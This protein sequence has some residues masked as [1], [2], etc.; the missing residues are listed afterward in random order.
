FDFKYAGWPTTRRECEA[1]RSRCQ[2]VLCAERFTS[3]G[4]ID[5]TMNVGHRKVLICT[6]IYYTWQRWQQQKCEFVR[7]KRSNSFAPSQ[8]R[9]TRKGSRFPEGCKAPKKSRIAARHNTL[10]RLRP[11]LRRYCLWLLATTLQV[12]ILGASGASYL[13]SFGVSSTMQPCLC[14]METLR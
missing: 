7:Q 13:F 11:L 3:G 8:A 12:R 5:S 14:S 4:V 6:L 2:N 9:R 1:A 10:C